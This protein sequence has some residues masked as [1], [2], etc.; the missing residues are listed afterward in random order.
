[1]RFWTVALLTGIGAALA[2]SSS[3]GCWS[4]CSCWGGDG[5]RIEATSQ[6]NPYRHVGVLL[7][8]GAITGLGKLVL[9]RL[10]SGNDLGHLVHGGKIS[11]GAG[12]VRILSE[13]IVGMGPWLRRRVTEAGGRR[14]RNIRPG[15]ALGQAPTPPAR[16]L[17]RRG[18]DGRRVRCPLGGALFALEVLRGLLALVSSFLRCSR[19]W[20]LDPSPGWSSPTL[21]RTT[22]PPTRSAPAPGPGAGDWPLAGLASVRRAVAAN[23]AKPTGKTRFI[24]PLIL[25]LLGLVS[26][27]FPQAAGKRKGRLPTAVQRQV[28]RCSCRR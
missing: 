18:G 22:C 6:A 14:R 23:R 9:V 24:A 10:T 12:K 3:P 2:Q 1:M 26:I 17:W 7:L 28:H 19:R 5:R 13:V 15:R 4:S 8:A 21:R 25:G 16:R 20:S 27:P 11:L